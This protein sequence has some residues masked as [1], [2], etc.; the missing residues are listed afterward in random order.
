MLFLAACTPPEPPAPLTEFPEVSAL[1]ERPELPPLFDS[2]NSKHVAKTAADW[3]DWR[4]PQLIALFDHYVYGARPPMVDVSSTRTASY[5]GLVPGARWEEWDLQLGGDARAVLHVAVIKPLSATGATPV[6]VG[7]NKC[8]NQSLV[9]D[10]RVRLT[11]S[12]VIPACGTSAAQ[13]R[14]TQATLWPLERII[15]RGFAV[16]T[17][18]ESDAAPD[19]DE[20]FATML[21][22]SFRAPEGTPPRAS[23]G[24]LSI[25]AWALAHV[26]AW[27]A[28]ETGL[29]STRIAVFGHSRRGK[30]ALLSGAVT[31]TFAAVIAHQSGTGGAAL[32][33]SAEGETIELINLAFPHWFDDVYPGFA[34]AET[35]T[36]VD[37]HQLLALW[38]PRRVV[39]V[40]ADEDRWADP[41]GAFAASVA[42]QPAWTLLGA[43][44]DLVSWQQ[45]LGMHSVEPSDWELFLDAL[46]W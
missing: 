24:T 16:V 33:R 23:W 42:A 45:R 46:G 36:P 10:P 7:L 4:R 29:D 39:L 38:A 1:P 8:G 26:G 18:H 37:Q 32:N 5:D 19:D 35:K 31:N 12:L 21:R 34:N 9:A 13:T 28:T 3:N 11:T 15:Q 41:D 20:K 6:I 17:F 43:S 2:F 22:A 30:A 27:T 44:T 40:D 14:G 25:W